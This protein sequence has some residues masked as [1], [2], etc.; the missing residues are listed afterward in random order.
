MFSCLSGDKNVIP[1]RKKENTYYFFLL[2]LFT[3]F[4]F[5]G[6]EEEVSGGSITWL[7][8]MP[9]NNDR[10]QEIVSKNGK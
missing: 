7:G 5:N 3:D 10:S 8:A 6:K 4:L 1:E 9:F 2:V